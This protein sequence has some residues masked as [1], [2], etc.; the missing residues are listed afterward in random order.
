MFFRYFFFVV[1]IILTTSFTITLSAF[2]L[3]TVFFYFYLYK[4]NQQFLFRGI[5]HILI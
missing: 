2:S 3:N 4:S 1:F 5:C